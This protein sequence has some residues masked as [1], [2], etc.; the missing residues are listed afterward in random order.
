MK[1]HKILITSALFLVFAL[2]SASAQAQCHMR[3]TLSEAKDGAAERFTLKSIDL[4]YGE[5]YGGDVEIFTKKDPTPYQVAAFDGH[6]KQIAAFALRSHR[7]TL[8]EEVGLVEVPTAEFSLVIAIDP[9]ARSLKVGPLGALKD[10]GL[11]PQD[12]ACAPTCIERG[13]LLNK[14]LNTCCPGL[15]AVSVPHK[16]RACVFC[17]DNVCSRYESFETCPADCPAKGR[18]KPRTGRNQ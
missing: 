5:V 6:G 8:A 1:A 4:L 16:G 3:L 9:R 17:G 15:M 7:F 12:L 10:L 14:H 2:F 13:H 18:R 11:S